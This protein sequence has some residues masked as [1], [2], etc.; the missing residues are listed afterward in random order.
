MSRAKIFMLSIVLLLS[1]CTNSSTTT[2]LS[3]GNTPIIN[4]PPTSSTT[5]VFNPTSTTSPKISISQRCLSVGQKE[6][7]LHD[8]ASGVVLIFPNLLDI[9][10][11]S[12]NEL[13]AERATPGLYGGTQVSPDR[14]MLAYLEDIQNSQKNISDQILWVVDAHAK[15]LARISFD[16]NDL[17]L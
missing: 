1:G 8:V 5:Q 6:I 17:E 16:R 4:E 12:V 11:G 15:V 14:N 7:P 2:P 10:S 9:Q 3:V 13:P